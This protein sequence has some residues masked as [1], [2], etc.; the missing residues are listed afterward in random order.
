MPAVLKSSLDDFKESAGGH[1]PCSQFHILVYF[2]QHV[3][4]VE[5]KNWKQNFMA[6]EISAFQ[7]CLSE[8]KTTSYC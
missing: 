7:S 5:M 3:H 6:D 1:H 2:A 4:K 8:A